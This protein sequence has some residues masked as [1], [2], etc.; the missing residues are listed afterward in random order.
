MSAGGI[1]AWARICQRVASEVAERMGPG[2]D[3][4]CVCAPCVKLYVEALHR[5]RR[6]P[7]R[8]E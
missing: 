1:G 2:H 8:C 5:E 7:L 3:A 6:R 4:T